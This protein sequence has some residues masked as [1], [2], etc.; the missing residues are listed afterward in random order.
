MAVALFHFQTSGPLHHNLL[1]GRSGRFVDFFFVLS[2]FVIAY[3]YSERLGRGGLRDFLVR[4]VARLWPLHAF[5]LAVCVCMAVAGGIA[6]LSVHGWAWSAI[7]ANLTL[8]HAWN[9][10]DRLT[11]N[12]PSWSISAE[13]AAYL[14]FALLAWSLAG[15]ALAAACASVML[16]ALALVLFAAPDGMGATFSWGIARCLYGFMAGALAWMARDRLGWRP[17][18]EIAALA[19]AMI[20]V[21][22][23]PG[24]A[25]AAIVPV[26]A[27]VVLVFASD[28]GPVSSLLHRPFPQRLGLLSYSIYMVHYVVGLG[29]MALLMLLTSLTREVEGTR[30]LVAPWWIT[31]PLTLAYLALVVIVSA[32]TH[33]RIERPGRRLFGLSGRP[34]PAAW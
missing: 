15:R 14:L 24:W 8:T 16:A 7:P 22:A 13:A 25:G 23:L 34:I 19:A 10:T 31:E 11:W 9:L 17:R 1:V 4:R 28:S 32:F 27:W 29:I 21:C 20:A 26:F 12:G 5:V 18:G 6:G 30:T 2:G 33:A 3:A